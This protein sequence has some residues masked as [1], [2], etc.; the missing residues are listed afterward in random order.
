MHLGFRFCIDE[1]IV[2]GNAEKAQGKLARQGDG[3]QRCVHDD[4]NGGHTT[5][6]LYHRSRLNGRRTQLKPISAA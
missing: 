4:K 5:G 6:S 3:T 2:R 1:L